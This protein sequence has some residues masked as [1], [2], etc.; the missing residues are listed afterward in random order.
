MPSSGPSI[1]TVSSAEAQ[2]V[3][4]GAIEA[5]KQIGIKVCVTVSDV[6]GRWIVINRM[7]GAPWATVFSSRGKAMASTAF[8]L[9]TG[10][11][12]GRPHPFV[13]K[14]E[15]SHM[16]IDQGA[17]AIFKNGLAVGAVGVDGGS[18]EQDEACA[19]A[20]AAKLGR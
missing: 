5:A 9:S 18:G 19:R 10:R 2:L 12:K 20:G 15:G 8:N 1:M 14:G 7:E 3:A 11:L 4:D 17:V 6:G 13:V 16:I